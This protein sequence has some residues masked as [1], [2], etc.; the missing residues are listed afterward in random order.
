MLVIERGLQ[1]VLYSTSSISTQGP[2]HKRET[3]LD[4]EQVELAN[5][6]GTLAERS[7]DPSKNPPQRSTVPAQRTSRVETLAIHRASAP[8]AGA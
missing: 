3:Q 5:A 8:R 1:I 4:V 2:S 6:C 7:C